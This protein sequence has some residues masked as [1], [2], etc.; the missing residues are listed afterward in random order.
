MKQRNGFVS[1]S[2]SASFIVHWRVRSMGDNYSIARALAKLFDIYSSFEDDKFNWE[3]SEWEASGWKD[4]IETLIEETRRN[5]DGTFTSSFFTSMMNS[6]E[7]FGE[8]A[9]SL[10]MGLVT[11]Y[12]E[13]QIIDTKVEDEGG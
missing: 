6:P 1:N 5:D 7:D 10:V 13:F 8:A 4:K 2:S 12:D 11:N 3:K 9:K